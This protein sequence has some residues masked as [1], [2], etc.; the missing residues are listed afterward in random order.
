MLLQLG[1]K[2][3]NVKYLQYGL[4]ILCCSPNGFDGE[5]GNGTRTAV[6]KFQSKYGLVS[7]GIV[8]DY[9][10]N[11]LK[12][13]ITTIQSQLNKK[14]FNIDKKIIELDHQ[15][16]TLGIHKVSI[17]LHKKVVASLTVSVKEV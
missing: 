10:W 13:E 17:K 1:D 11:T 4:H 8:G 12:N 9:T 14:G 3:D 7:D 16:D 6:K 2:G 15:I 5:F